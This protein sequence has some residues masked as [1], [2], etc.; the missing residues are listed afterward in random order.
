VKIRRIRAAVFREPHFKMPLILKQ[1]VSISDSL[2]LCPIV[3][4]FFDQTKWESTNKMIRITNLCTYYIQFFCQSLFLSCGHTKNIDGLVRELIW[5]Y[6]LC[7]HFTGKGEGGG[8]WKVA[9]YINSLL[10]FETWHNYSEI[11]QPS[12]LKLNCQRP[13]K[14]P[15]HWRRW[16]FPSYVRTAPTRAL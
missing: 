6:G 8:F 12:L 4:F 16:A 2:C 15:D 14:N 11:D 3:I 7:N 1:L 9:C 13:R 5:G 10:R